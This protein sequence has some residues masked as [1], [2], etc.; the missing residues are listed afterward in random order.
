MTKHLL[1]ILIALASFAISCGDDES[2]FSNELIV[3]GT[4][5]P[6]DQVYYQTYTNSFD[7]DIHLFY[8]L[9]EG[10]AI[11][12]NDYTGSGKWFFLYL[13]TEGE[14]MEEATYSFSSNYEYA[15]YGEFTNGEYDLISVPEITGTGT[16]EKSGS[17]YTMRFTAE[18]AT[19][20]FTIKYNGTLETVSMAN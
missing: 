13:F 3:N 12:N 10:A 19:H 18:S 20:D 6:I 7:Q 9:E 14:A 16:I 5:Y 2:T 1:L 4:R 8:I 15:E 11:V 17:T